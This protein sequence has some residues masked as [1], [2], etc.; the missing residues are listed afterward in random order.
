LQLNFGHISN[1]ELHRRD[2]EDAEITQ[3]LWLLVRGKCYIVQ[4]DATPT[5]NTLNSSLRNLCV[6]CVSAVNKK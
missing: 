1:N 2:A 5:K 6:L 4:C 3:R